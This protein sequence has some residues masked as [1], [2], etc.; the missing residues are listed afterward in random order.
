MHR[1]SSSATHSTC[2]APCLSPTAS[3]VTPPAS[4]RRRP[5]DIGLSPPRRCHLSDDHHRDGMCC[6]DLACSVGGADSVIVIL[7]RS[8]AR[9]A[10]DEK[11]L[12]FT[13]W[14]TM[15]NPSFLERICSTYR[16][17]A[18]DTSTDHRLS[19]LS[20]RA[21]C[22]CRHGNACYDSFPFLLRVRCCTS[23]G[24]RLSHLPDRGRDGH[25]LVW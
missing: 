8:Q 10:N 4:D 21:C 16:S 25:D 12:R 9:P 11:S 24:H 20:E 3:T 23:A 2:I 15:K 22:H 14:P 1:P 13:P 18:A 5:A 19:H 7:L 6:Y 17:L